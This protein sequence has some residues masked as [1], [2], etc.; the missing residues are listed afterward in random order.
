MIFSTLQVAVQWIIQNG[1]LLMFLIMLAE[2][3]VVTAAGAFVAALGFFNI[4][5]VLVLSLLGN[6]IPDILYY[7][8]GFWGREQFIDKYGHY[9]GLDK[10]KIKHLENMIEKHAVKS[11]IV[12]KL[13]PLLATPGLIVA[14]LTKMDIKKY[15]KWSLIITIPSS[16]FYLIIGYYFG[17]AYDTIAR[18]LRIG[19]YLALF[20]VIIFAA[21]IYLERKLSRR[22]A[23]EMER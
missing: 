6:L 17:A 3:P 14:G 8:M 1:Y 11:L 22:F 20:F 18:Y 19:G 13:V 16:L 7:A 15:I 10:D 4:W 9:F 5:V 12:I 23:E 21:I 2:G